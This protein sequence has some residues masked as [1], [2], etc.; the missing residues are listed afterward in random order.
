MDIS[1][2]AW[3]LTALNIRAP[4]VLQDNASPRTK[5]AAS[6][7]AALMSFYE[8]TVS[9]VRLAQ[10]LKPPANVHTPRS[11]ASDNK[12]KK[13]WPKEA[14]LNVLLRDLLK[15]NVAGPQYPQS[16]A[17]DAGAG[18]S[19]D[20]RLN[21]DALDAEMEQLFENRDDVVQQLALMDEQ[22]RRQAVA[23]PKPL[24]VGD[25]SAALIGPPQ[26]LT[27]G[28]R[29]SRLA[30]RITIL[31]SIVS[32]HKQKPIQILLVMSISSCT[33]GRSTDLLLSM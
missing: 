3:M 30:H 31:Y 23:M 29:Y 33:R 7:D 26:P 32:L 21:E 18:S 11:G 14:R 2:T 1:I 8:F 15:M 4:H 16:D 10:K 6:L 9:L 25:S 22:A 24:A 27:T 13:S 17:P 12:A 19:A 28:K 5:A 20:Y